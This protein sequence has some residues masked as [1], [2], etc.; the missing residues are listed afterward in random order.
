MKTA[1][2]KEDPL[3][4][5]FGRS[6]LPHDFRGKKVSLNSF[7]AKG[8]AALDWVNADGLKNISERG[9]VIQVVGKSADSRNVFYGLARSFVLKSIS[10]RCLYPTDLFHGEITD[11]LSEELENRG[12]LFIDKMGVDGQ[13]FIEPQTAFHLEVFLERWLGSGKS[14]ALRTEIDIKDVKQWSESFRFFVR[15][16]LTQTFF[17]G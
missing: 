16:R 11:Q 4:V 17:V 10:T 13:N 14:F 1:P 9:I 12:C 15:S 6:H 3:Q 7:G 8:T 5:S 2:T